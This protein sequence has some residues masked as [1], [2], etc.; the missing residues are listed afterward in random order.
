MQV[1]DWNNSHPIAWHAEFAKRLRA[2]RWVAVP[3]RIVRGRNQ[4]T[5]KMVDLHCIERM[6]DAGH[7]SSTQFPF[8]HLRKLLV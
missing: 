3:R 6:K 4:L 8:T 2:T 5:V 1:L 7:T